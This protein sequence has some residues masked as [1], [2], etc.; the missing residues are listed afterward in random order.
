METPTEDLFFFFHIVATFHYLLG[1]FKWSTKAK[2][3]REPLNLRKEAALNLQSFDHCREPVHVPDSGLWL[4]SRKE[5]NLSDYNTVQYSVIVPLPRCQGHLDGA[6]GGI[7]SKGSR[8]DL[9]LELS[10]RWPLAKGVSTGKNRGKVLKDLENM[11]C[12]AKWKGGQGGL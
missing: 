6:W 12:W 3:A 8:E 9:V 4:L 7:N 10:S 1:I 5:K 11:G 2:E